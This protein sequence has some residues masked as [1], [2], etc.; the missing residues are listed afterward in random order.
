MLVSW[1]NKMMKFKVKEER[2][3]ARAHS[4]ESA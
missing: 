2:E 3:I 4:R 1:G